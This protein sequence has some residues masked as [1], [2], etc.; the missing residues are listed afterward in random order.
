VFE[1]RVLRRIYGLKREQMARRW[2]ILHGE[3]LHDI[4][5]SSNIVR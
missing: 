5:A 2:R 4:H 3:E 1:N